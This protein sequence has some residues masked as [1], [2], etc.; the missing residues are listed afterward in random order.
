[1][2]R[3]ALK[4][5]FLCVARRRGEK[6]TCLIFSIFFRFNSLFRYDESIF[7]TIFGSLFEIGGRSLGRLVSCPFRKSL[8]VLGKPA[9][10]IHNIYIYIYYNIYIKK[11]CDILQL[12]MQP[13]SKSLY[14]YILIY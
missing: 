1:M 9:V 8:Q 12:R 4:D 10:A 14:M 2:E 3:Y 7:E 6:K 5:S 11:N 13:T